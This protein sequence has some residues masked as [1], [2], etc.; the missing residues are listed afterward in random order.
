MCIRDSWWYDFKL[1]IARKLVFKK[2]QEALGGGIVVIASGGAALNPRLNRI[3]WAAGMPVFEGYGLTE[4]S[5]VIT[6]NYFGA[7]SYTHLDVY[8]RQKKSC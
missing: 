6:V 4:T 8:K 2:W 5:P 1:G 3:F 7:V